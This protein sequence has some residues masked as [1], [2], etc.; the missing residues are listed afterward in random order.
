M[1]LNS[2]EKEV[3]FLKAITELIDTMVNY[4]VLEVVGSDPDSEVRF[5]SMTH[6]AFF[7]IIL[8]DFLSKTD[9]R[10]LGESSSYLV[11]LQSICTS[12]HFNQSNSVDSLRQATQE[13]TDWLEKEMSV[14]NVWLPSIDLEISLKIK[15]FEFIK[16]CGNISKH[17]F[18]RLGAVSNELKA[19]FQRNGRVLS[20]EESLL[21]FGEF[22]EWFHTNIFSYHSSAIAE[23]LNNIRWG[24]YEYL[25]PEFNRS[26]VRHKEPSYGYHY[27]YPSNIHNSFAKPCYWELMNDVR[28]KPF[29][30]KFQ[31]T[32]FLKMRY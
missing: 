11:A 31:V 18:T 9:N 23:F 5:K 4:E 32:R 14:E 15:R 27:T 2:I 21:I 22:Y 28:S 17:N 10:I 7:N 26:I 3:I 29:V 13:F 6:Q 16:I 25:Q 20:D 8:V 1:Q 19:I 30:P 12:P 24:I